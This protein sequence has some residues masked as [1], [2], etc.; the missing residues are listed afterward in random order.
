MKKE[1]EGTDTVNERVGFT[2]DYLA[3]GSREGAVAV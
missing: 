3:T 2:H 1:G